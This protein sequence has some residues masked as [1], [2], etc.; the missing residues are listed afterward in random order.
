MDTSDLEFRILSPQ[1]QKMCLCVG[2]K[3]RPLNNT[4]IPTI[5]YPVPT[6]HMKE[7]HE[8]E[9]TL[10]KKKIRKKIREFKIYF[11]K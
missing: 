2:T 6:T 10:K 4:P 5:Y 3:G 8:F 1:P 9:E 7:K 11:C